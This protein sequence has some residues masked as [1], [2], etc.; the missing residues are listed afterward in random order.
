METLNLLLTLLIFGGMILFWKFY[1]PS[2][3]KKKGEN[4]A[5]KED[6]A[7]IT[8][9]IEG[10]KSTYS[11]EIERLRSEL[12]KTVLVH[13]LQFETEFQSYR[14]MWEK[15]LVVRNRSLELRPMM[16]VYVPTEEERNKLKQE[17]MVNFA[18]AFNA[19]GEVAEKNKPFYPLVIWK[20]LES[21]LGT[22]RK[23]AIGYQYGDPDSD[24]RKYWDEALKN[25][26]SIIAQID[27]ICE[28]IR[29]RIEALKGV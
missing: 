27:S 7:D 1:L 6:I 8:R 9:Q 28:A 3:F 10:V 23:E 11:S 5:Q 25:R 26:D 29:N 21:L 20:E 19:F 4:L 22:I 17:R 15:L 16:D 18:N 2:Y 12:S 14:E 24:G 13:K